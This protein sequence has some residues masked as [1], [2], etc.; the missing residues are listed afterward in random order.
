MY[1]EILIFVT[2]TT[3][4]II[5]ETLYVLA[6]E[7]EETIT[8]DEIYII[9]TLHGKKRIEEELM[10]SGRFAA[11]CE[12][13]GVRPELLNENSFILLHD[14]GNTPLEDIRTTSDNENAGDAIANFIRE[15]TSD[16]NTRLHCSIAG[17]RK[18]MSFYLGSALQLFGRP[19][20]RLYHV[21]VTPEFESNPEFY[22]KPAEGREIVIRGKN[23]TITRR[24]Y[25]ED[26][27]I[28][29]AELPFIRLRDKLRLNGKTFRDLVREGQREIDT[30]VAQPPLRIDLKERVVAIGD[31]SIEFKPI[32]LVIYTYLLKQ[33]T[34][35]CLYREQPY[36][37]DC[38][39]CFLQI[40]DISNKRGMEAIL[41]DYEKIYGH[42]SGHVENFKRTWKDGIDP[43]KL[44]SDISKINKDIR[45]SLNDETLSTL[46]T[47]AAVK[48]YAAT[49]YGVRVEKRK[50]GVE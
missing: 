17:G 6:T 39:D 28:E 45:E 12:E 21:L 10:H 19:W 25:T 49:R 3:P 20:D 9:T 13:Y 43:A 7:R 14:P 27:E 47:I 37:H 34:E 22:Y 46:Y 33:K 18:T 36:C 26:A 4:Q 32:H 24:L 1:R 42:Y 50:I 31:V 30:V 16:M 5:T 35:R 48:K 41:K 2:G 8:P 29:L 44:R 15:K 11:F 40:T 38:T 23:G